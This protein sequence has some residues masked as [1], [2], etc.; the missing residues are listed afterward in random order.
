MSYCRYLVALVVNHLNTA[1]AEQLI[2]FKKDVDEL[3]EKGEPKVSHL[4]FE[5]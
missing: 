3:M 4:L 1:V 5:E 2:E